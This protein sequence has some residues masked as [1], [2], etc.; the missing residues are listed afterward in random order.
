MKTNGNKMPGM[1]VPESVYFMIE[2]K[3][4]AGLKALRNPTWAGRSL[5]GLCYVLGYTPDFLGDL[6]PVIW[7]LYASGLW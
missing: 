1:S 6:A 4:I 5:Q 3:Y 2:N 7:A